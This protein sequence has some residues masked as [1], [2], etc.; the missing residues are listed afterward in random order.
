MNDDPVANK[1][2]IQLD[3]IDFENLEAL[4]KKMGYRTYKYTINYAVLVALNPPIR[5]PSP[6]VKK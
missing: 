4:R 6:Q 5:G 3:G 1:C 2:V